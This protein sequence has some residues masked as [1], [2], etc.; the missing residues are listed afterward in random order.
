M[1]IYL[2]IFI[3][4]LFLLFFLHRSKSKNKRLDQV[5]NLFLPSGISSPLRYDSEVGEYKIRI[6]LGGI[7]FEVI[8]D[9]GSH[10]LIVA[11]PQCSTCRDEKG[12]W[13][14]ILGEKIDPHLQEI[15]YYGSQKTYYTLWKATLNQNGKV[16]FGVIEKSTINVGYS[17]NVLGLQFSSTL[18]KKKSFLQSFSG[19]KKVLFDFPSSSFHLGLNPSSL[20]SYLH[21]R[22]IIDTIPIHFLGHRTL[23]LLPIASI[24]IN[25]LPTKWKPNWAIIDT[26]TTM[27]LVEPQLYKYLLASQKSTESK[28]I[29]IHFASE[30]EKAISFPFYHI[31]SAGS[32]GLP[33]KNVILLG[34]QWLSRYGLYIDYEER[35]FSF[36]L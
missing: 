12:V 17:E 11:G 36:F 15:E 27:T 25:S 7:P 8:P 24:Q 21:S 26:G 2:L 16:I 23:I 6:D 13:N 35:K 18:P 32:N 9:T 31:K 19:P 22:K 1:W 29:S 30:K 28:E 34:N 4:I 3:L 5:A 14:P 20:E 10:L 33:M